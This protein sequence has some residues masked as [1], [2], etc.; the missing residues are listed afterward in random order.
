MNI[1]AIIGQFKDRPGFRELPVKNFL[2]SLGDSTRGN[3]L[4]NLS[5]DTRLYA[6]KPSIVAAIKAGITAKFKP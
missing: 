2:G 5:M 6:W 4:A 1:E 3:A